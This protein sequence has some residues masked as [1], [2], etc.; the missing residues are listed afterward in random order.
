M[1]WGLDVAIFL[2]MLGLVCACSEAIQEQEEFNRVGNELSKEAKKHYSDGDFI[3]ADS[4]FNRAFEA[5]KVEGDTQLMGQCLNNRGI[6]QLKRGAS[7]EKGLRY[8]Y[9]ALELYRDAG[10]DSLSATTVYNIGVQFKKVGS[11]ESAQQHVLEALGTM[12]ALEG[13]PDLFAAYST[14]GNLER[15]QGHTDRS[16]QYFRKADSALVFVPDSTE[17]KAELLL[18]QAQ[19]FRDLKKYE[20]AQIN[21][22]H[23]QSLFFR[24]KDSSGLASATAQL[25][26]V[27][28]RE[29]EYDQAEEYL[30][31]ALNLRKEIGEKKK[32]A[33]SYNHLG[34]LHTWLEKDDLA[35]LY[36]DTALTYSKEVSS[37]DYRLD[38]LNLRVALSST[39]KRFEEALQWKEKAVALQDSLLGESTR[40][41]IGGFN[42][43]YGLEKKQRELT[44]TLAHVEQ[45][46]YQSRQIFLVLLMLAGTAG[47]LLYQYL[48]KRKEKNRIENLLKET[49]H[50]IKNNL[51][52]LSGLLSLEQ[53]RLKKEVPRDPEIVLRDAENRLRAMQIVH[54]HLC[55]ATEKSLADI[56]LDS[57][58]QQL[59]ENLELVMPLNDQQVQVI[60]QLDEVF[61]DVNKAMRL[62]L[63]INE[64]ICNAYKHA[65]PSGQTDAQIAIS[66][67]KNE[68]NEAEIRVKDNGVGVE[69]RKMKNDSLGLS[70]V[71]NL[72]HEMGGRIQILSEHGCEA[73][74]SMK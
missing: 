27:S 54:E 16:L 34:E 62:G 59:G 33:S 14:M 39:Q 74:I 43:R 13:H 60:Y 69:Q 46:E 38:N 6:S 4:L 23:A 10:L 71:Q 64:L 67:Q 3:A 44:E 36:L 19:T 56:R 28:I 8:F 57:Y 15:K 17:Q 68:A 24:I 12:E 51:Q 61:L 35:K 1:K 66:V 42:A 55:L 48:Q 25:G 70:L 21:L 20:A 22:M 58:V 9:E 49:H 26:V 72:T 2:G 65:F 30:R 37:R 63:V 18:H 32:L 5:A 50:R 40:F 7:S 73:V 45:V 53:K 11:Y 52:S 47:F 41:A 29:K 31:N